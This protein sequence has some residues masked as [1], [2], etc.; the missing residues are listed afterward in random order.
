VEGDVGLGVFIA[1]D[2]GQ[3]GLL[4]IHA[5]V[6]FVEPRGDLDA[7]LAALPPTGW[8]AADRIANVTHDTSALAV[9]SP[10]P[11]PYSALAPHRRR[12][13]GRLGQHELDIGTDLEAAMRQAIAA[14]EA[15]GWTVEN[16]GAY[17]FFSAI[18]LASRE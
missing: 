3:H 12:I 9:R 4:T 18:V 13:S 8:T 5:Q 11:K 6:P 2:G 1:T 16:D 17:G 10:E 7:A 15:D 14:C